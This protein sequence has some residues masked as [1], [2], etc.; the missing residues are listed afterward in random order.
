MPSFFPDINIAASKWDRI[1]F[2][3]QIVNFGVINSGITW[4]T[5]GERD[6]KNVI[7]WKDF[8]YEQIP[9]FVSTYH[10]NTNNRWIVEQDMSFNYYLQWT[11]HSELDESKYC[12]LQIATHEFGHFIKLKDLPQNVCHE[13]RRY[14]MY[15]HGWEGLHNKETLTCEDKWGAWWTYNRMP[16]RR[17]PSAIPEDFPPPLQSTASML[18]TRLLQNYPDPFNPETWI[19][20]ELASHADVHIDIYNSSGGLV[21]QIMIGQQAPGSYVQTSKAAYWDGKDANGIEVASGTT[22]IHSERMTSR[23]LSGWLS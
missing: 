17:A 10:S 14:V 18:Q 20:Y 19:P 15:A 21:R 12:L 11:E 5:P 6:Y 13:Y 9:A 23:R 2:D 16:W 3:G 8:Q 1:E 7:G 4:L 22:S